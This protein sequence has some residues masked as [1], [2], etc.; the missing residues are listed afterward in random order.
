MPFL[1]FKS[2]SLPGKRSLS[3]HGV[4]ISFPEEPMEREN[5]TQHW[6]LDKEVHPLMPGSNLFWVKERTDAVCVVCLQYLQTGSFVCL[7]S[8]SVF[9]KSMCRSYA[10]Y[11]TIFTGFLQSQNIWR[12]QGIIM[13]INFFSPPFIWLKWLFC[14]CNS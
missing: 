14:E 3:L 11:L 5:L 12:Y 2:I 9:V 8:H 4:S 1:T 10:Y 6:L 7:Y 13:V